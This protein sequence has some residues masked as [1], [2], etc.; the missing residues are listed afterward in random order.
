VYRVKINGS[1]LTIGF[2]TGLKTISV[3]VALYLQY[4]S[5]R[6]CVC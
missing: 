1:L 3:G 2:N 6:K 4:K 5:V